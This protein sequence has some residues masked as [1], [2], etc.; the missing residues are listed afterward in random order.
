[1]FEKVG[2]KK[3][4]GFQNGP[5]E[6][7][8]RCWILYNIFVKSY[9]K[10]LYQM[11][12]WECAISKTKSWRACGG[13]VGLERCLWF[14]ETPLNFFPSCKR[15]CQTKWYVVML[16]GSGE[17]SLISWDTSQFFAFMQA[18]MPDQMVC[19]NALKSANI[20]YEEQ[21]TLR[22]KFRKPINTC[23]RKEQLRKCKT[24]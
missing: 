10:Q 11:L 7:N 4:R 16:C 22:Q 24:L 6:F 1:M 5:N 8:L 17:V 19:C 13:A 18:F 2:P 15:L 14:R 12:G 9:P 20:K 23:G 21:Q 3:W